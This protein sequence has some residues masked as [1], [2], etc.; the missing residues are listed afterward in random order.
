MKH[1]LMMNCPKTGYQPF[2]TR[3]KKDIQ[4][5]IEFMHSFNRQL[6]ESG[7]W[8]SGEGLAGPQEAILVRAGHRRRFSGSQGVSRRPL[9]C[10]GR[11]SGAS[12]CA[13]SAGLGC[14]GAR[15]GTLQ[16]ADR[17]ATAAERSAKRTPVARMCRDVKA[18]GHGF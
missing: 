2:G 5:H 3:P 12:L 18:V 16:H 4:A 11:D 9:D 13:P 15:R 17:G 1:I 8:V 7:E 6:C 10:R 14:A